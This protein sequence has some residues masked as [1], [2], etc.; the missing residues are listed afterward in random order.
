MLPAPAIAM[1]LASLAMHSSS[2]GPRLAMMQAVLP[3]RPR[4][5]GRHAFI[6][7]DNHIVGGMTG[8]H[9]AS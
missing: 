4:T 5:S 9:L 2:P 6:G 8:D 1:V 3:E 7:D